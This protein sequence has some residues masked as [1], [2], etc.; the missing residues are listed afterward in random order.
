MKGKGK[1][2]GEMRK[3]LTLLRVEKE[4]FDLFP[5]KKNELN[6]SFFLFSHFFFLT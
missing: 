3:K 5:E 2:K 6:Y 1:K 4:F